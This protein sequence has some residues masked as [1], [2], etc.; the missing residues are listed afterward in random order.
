M[1]DKDSKNDMD[2][3]NDKNKCSDLW[4]VILHYES[5]LNNE[6]IISHFCFETLAYS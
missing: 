1:N 3:E 4:L 5:L 2:D 6:R